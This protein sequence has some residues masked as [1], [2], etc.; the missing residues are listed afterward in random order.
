[1]KNKTNVGLAVILSLTAVNY[2]IFSSK[3]LALTNETNEKRIQLLR[4]RFLRDRFIKG[5][6]TSE[7]YVR[8]LKKT[9]AAMRAEK[10]THLSKNEGV[11]LCGF[12]NKN[13]LNFYSANGTKVKKFVID[14]KE[15]YNGKSSLKCTADFPSKWSSFTITFSKNTTPVKNGDMHIAVWKKSNRV[16]FGRLLYLI[17]DSHG[18]L[19]E[20]ILTKALYGGGVGDSWS[21]IISD[22]PV[23][24]ADWKGVSDAANN[25]DFN[26]LIDYP[27]YLRA[28]TIISRGV[29]ENITFY[30]DDLCAVSPEYVKEAKNG[31][32]HYYQNSW[33]L[34]PNCGFEHNGYNG[35]SETIANWHSS[36]NCWKIDN[37][38]EHIGKASLTV[39]NTTNPSKIDSTGISLIH[40]LNTY[41]LSGWV[42][43]DGIAGLRIGM[44]WYRTYP[45]PGAQSFRGR[46][47]MST[48]W[49]ESIK[50]TNTWKKISIKTQPPEGARWVNFAIEA[51]TGKGKAWIDDLEF[52]GFGA[53]PIQII[54]SQAGY[55]PWSKKEILV[56]TRKPSTGGSLQ[57]IDSK[58]EKTVFSGKLKNFGK[59]TWGHYN[60][61][62]DLSSFSKEG[63]YVL[64]VVVEGIG[65]AES[66]RIQIKKGLYSDLARKGL[67]YCYIQRCGMAIPGWHGACHL[68]DAAGKDEN[69]NEINVDLTGGW[70]DAGDYSKQ[71]NGDCDM[72]RALSIL[73]GNLSPNWHKL[74]DKIPDPLG[75]AWWGANFLLKRYMG[76][77]RYIA[78]TIYAKGNTKDGIL[79]AYANSPPEELTD[80]VPGTSD[81]RS[82]G[83]VGSGQSLNKRI[84][85]QH[86]SALAMYAKVVKSYDKQKY[87]ACMKVILE[88]YER[89]HQ[90]HEDPKKAIHHDK[91]FGKLQILLCELDPANRVIHRK[92]AAEYVEKILNTLENPKIQGFIL[93]DEE[94]CPWPYIKKKYAPAHFCFWHYGC[95]AYE[96]IE[97]LKMYADIFPDNELMPKIKERIRWFMETAVVPLTSI[98]PYGHMMY[99]DLHNP[100]DI[101]P[102][103]ADD[104]SYTA[105][106]FPAG[107]NQYLAKISYISSLAAQLLNE[108]K[109]LEIAE[110]QIQWIMGHNPRGESMMGGVGYREME[111]GT[112]LK[113]SPKID[114]KVS[115]PGGVVI[116]IAGGFPRDTIYVHP[117]GFPACSREVWQR[118]TAF[119]ILAC[120]EL[121][122]AK[123]HYFPDN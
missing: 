110:Q 96:F 85:F 13:S 3:V 97:V 48:S 65:R 77:G 40:Y 35:V 18:E 5:E 59:Y 30:F 95:T 22:K 34:V 26:G 92:R 58:S 119:T 20:G 107:Y 117:R 71:G 67:E 27:V 28:L 60:W 68:D 89:Y 14:K 121:E 79:L 118:S 39:G 115:I 104:G 69:G 98:S 116:G 102:N 8:L 29:V 94:K 83:T 111:C 56:R 80:N 9:Q 93:L 44:N 23:S 42:K 41:E 31:E 73:Q 49:S 87:D 6:V 43:T 86:L 88:L 76:N 24:S 120:Q 91:S 4:D 64:K 78:G 1:M 46:K 10:S 50:G 108:P 105:T 47:F 7:T 25:S 11:R 72:V 61:I 55:T 21:R 90:E 33:N 32:L 123:K 114:Y 82:F 103:K 106:S 57:L 2:C 100:E 51:D 101:R 74:R 12:E 17:E 122:Y 66:H 62:A 75:E 112:M 45:M 109:Y 38:E 54:E 37:K 70:H 113:G 53:D 19:F 63:D 16:F 99:L 52:D 84:L 81:D 36:D 15:R